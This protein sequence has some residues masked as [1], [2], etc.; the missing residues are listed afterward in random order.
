MFSLRHAIALAALLFASAVPRADAASLRLHASRQA[1]DSVG[2]PAS[3]I[4]APRADTDSLDSAI[5]ARIES[6]LA[7]CCDPRATVSVDIADA[8]TGTRLYRLDPKRS[9]RPASCQKTITAWVAA[10]VLGN[11]FRFRTLLYADNALTDSLLR[12]NLYVYG[13]M[14][15]LLS[16]ND[17]RTLADSLAARG[18]RAIAGDIV[19]DDSYKDHVRAGVGWCWDDDN[20]VLT[21]LLCEG[22]D[23]LPSTLV[24]EFERAGIALGGGLRMG[25]VPDTAVVVGQC[26]HTLAAVFQPMLKNSRNICAESVFYALGRHAGRC[27]T[28]LEAAVVIESLVER[29]GL[30][31][32]DYRTADGSGLSLYNYASAELLCSILV[33]AWN[34][35]A[36]RRL[37]LPALPVAGEDGTLARRMRSGPA[38]GKVRAKTGTLTG[39]ST[40]SGFAET[41]DGRTLAFSIF[42]SGYLN[43]TDFHRLQD[44]LCAALTAP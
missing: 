17:L 7:R 36:C 26:A 34:D 2:V 25:F 39:V 37:L 14:D 11:E 31:V 30:R 18:L 12:G 28:A 8:S 21:P 16:R 24:E 1:E 10:C 27:A 9:M 42:C 32:A 29:L 3:R 40:L 33:S 44:A 22:R 41:A 19:F 23:I 6:V 43:M 35:E 15:P 5:V 20:P 4:V 13:E 38:R